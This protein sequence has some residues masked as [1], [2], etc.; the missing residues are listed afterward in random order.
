M[1][2][3]YDEVCLKAFPDDEAV[4]RL[5]TAKGA[6]PLTPEQVRVTFNDD[7]GCGWLLKDGQRNIQVM[8][9]LPPYHACSVR[10]TLMP[11]FAIAEYRAITET[12]KS[13]RPGFAEMQPQLTEIQD[14]RISA[15]GESRALPDGRTEALLVIDQQATDPGRR[16]AGAI[17][18]DIRFVHQ[19]IDRDAR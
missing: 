11:G 9:E 17:G 19:I 16:A 8:L 3:L 5:M 13:T 12:Y 1:A 4:D 7:P 15:R 6:T 14:F 10:R 18:V 2:A